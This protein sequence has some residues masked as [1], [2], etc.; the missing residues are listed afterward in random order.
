MG[1]TQL[2]GA[3]GLPLAAT[4]LVLAARW[5][6]RTPPGGVRPLRLC[7]ARAASAPLRRLSVWLLALSL[8]GLLRPDLPGVPYAVAWGLLLFA[9]CALPWRRARRRAARRPGPG[10]DAGPLAR[11]HELP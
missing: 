1:L 4:G 6:R 8:L 3:C 11:P 9:A 10:P 5:R 7:A 2:L